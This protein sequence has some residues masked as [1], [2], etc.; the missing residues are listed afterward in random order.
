MAGVVVLHTHRFRFV[1]EFSSQCGDPLCR[2]PPAV[3]GEARMLDLKFMSN[4]IDLQWS[5]AT[6]PKPLKL[7]LPGLFGFLV[8]FL[9]S[10]V[11]VLCKGF[12]VLFSPVAVFD[13]DVADVSFMLLLV[14]VKLRTLLAEDVTDLRKSVFRRT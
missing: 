7:L 5:T 3:S 2:D 9:I 10:P 13:P 12:V 8:T 11:R 6:D 4:D 14:R 1:A